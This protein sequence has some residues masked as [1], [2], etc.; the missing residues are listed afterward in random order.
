MA[1][2]AGQTTPIPSIENLQS[3]NAATRST[4][5]RQ[6]PVIRWTQCH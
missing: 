4:G 3:S 6:N 5:D 2:Q 1:V